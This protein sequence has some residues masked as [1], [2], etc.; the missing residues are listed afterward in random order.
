MK[1]EFS[2]DKDISLIAYDNLNNM[3]VKNLHLVIR[4]REFSVSNILA[5]P[6]PVKNENSGV[7]FTFILSK[8]SWVEIKVFT[9]GGRLVWTSGR[10]YFNQGFGKIYWNLRDNF[11]DNISNGFYIYKLECKNEEG[12]KFEIK[13]G[14]LIAK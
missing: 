13:K 12:R 8:P 5:Y 11:N 6:N 3:S 7:Y 14:L 1:F 2:Q 4:E 10:R 9:I